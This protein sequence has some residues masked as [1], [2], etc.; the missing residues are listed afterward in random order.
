MEQYLHI[1]G[2][3]GEGG[4][5]ILRTALTLSVLTGRAVRIWRVRATRWNPGLAPQHLTNVNALAHICDAKVLDARIGSR[6]IRFVPRSKPRPGIYLFDVSQQAPGG[7][8]GSTTLIF[9]TLL[10]PLIFAAGESLITLR[11]G[12]HVPW[13]PSFDELAGVFLPSVAGMG[14]IAECRLEA[15][16]FYPRGGGQIVGRIRG[17]GR[18][19]TPLSLHKRGGL[20]RVAGRAVVCNL[21]STIANRMTTYA[22]KFLRAEGFPVEIFPRCEHGVGPGAGIFLIA[23]YEYAWAGLS[24]L[25]ERGKPSEEVAAEACRALIEHHAQGAPIDRHLADQLILPMALA[26]GR[27]E[28]RTSCLTRH[29]LTNVHVIRQFIPAAVQIEGREGRGGSVIV[30]GVGLS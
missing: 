11:G 15:W 25:G 14:V 29:L 6:E 20:K 10:W 16:G 26:K 27:S 12:T 22:E 28:L 19:L 21:P 13:S 1:D 17:T 7:S 30:E 9:Q 24:A 8:A 4:G 2:S 18:G 23:E 5:Q 3:Y